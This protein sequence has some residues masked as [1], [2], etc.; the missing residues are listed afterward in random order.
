MTLEDGVLGNAGEAAAEGVDSETGDW[1]GLAESG[2]V[3]R[4]DPVVPRQAGKYRGPHGAA[5]LDATVEQQQRWA[6]A[7]LDEGG[8][9]PS[10]STVRVAAGSRASIRSLGVVVVIAALRV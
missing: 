10:T 4:H 8:D 5:A 2:D 1:S 3:G 9:M 6:V 7:C